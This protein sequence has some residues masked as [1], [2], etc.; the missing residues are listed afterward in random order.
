M[1]YVFGMT[2]PL[3]VAWEMPGTYEEALLSFDSLTDDS[4]ITR[5]VR[6]AS[7]WRQLSFRAS[8]LTIELS[9]TTE[10]PVRRLMGQLLPRQP[11][12][13][14]IRYGDTILSVQADEL[15]RFVAD[16]IPAGAISI[17]CRLGDGFSDEAQEAPPVVTGWISI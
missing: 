1:G 11:A 7:A 12:Q 3:A 5:G 2:Q 4:P 9:V 14:D 8:G 10:G 13:V 16:D 17:R 6:S 15:G